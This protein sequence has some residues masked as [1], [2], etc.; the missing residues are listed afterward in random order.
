[1]IIGY[2]N[3]QKFSAKEPLTIQYYEPVNDVGEVISKTINPKYF[4][5]EYVKELAERNHWRATQSSLL[6]D[7]Y[8]ALQEGIIRDKQLGAGHPLV[9]V[10]FN[11]TKNVPLIEVPGIHIGKE[12]TKE[13]GL[14]K[15]ELLSPELCVKFFETYL[16]GKYTGDY[17][18]WPCGTNLSDV[19]GAGILPILEEIVK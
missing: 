8:V 1:M 19:K 10:L 18:I 5:D 2:R 6:E 9:I 7:N 17:F 11:Y 3:K 15:V 4:T 16:S 13:N 14:I 12:K